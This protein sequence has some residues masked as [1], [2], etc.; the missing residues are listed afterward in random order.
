MGGDAYAAV[1]RVATALGLDTDAVVD[2]LA[3]KV[4]G[5]DL[6]SFLL[7]V[8][9]RR[10]EQLSPADIMRRARTDPLVEP[11]VVDAR[12]LHRVIG[13]VIDTIPRGFDVVELAPVVPLGTHSSVATVHQH[14][15]VSTIRNTE[16]AADPTN[17][18]AVL[19]ALRGPKREP[20]RL[21]AVQRILRAQPFG[22][23][24]QQH[25]SVLGLVTAGRDRGDLAFETDALVE[26]LHVLR[27]A[28]G[29][30]TNA[31][32]QIRLTDLAD[33]RAAALVQGAAES[34]ADDADTLVT[35]DPDRPT[36]R[37]YYRDLCFKIVA[38][39]TDREVEIGDGGFTDWTAQLL[40]DRKARLLT[41]GLGLDRLTSLTN[42]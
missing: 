21:A 3:T 27:S 6:T 40:N 14:K 24:G 42:C 29:T 34:F 36:G 1:R 32:V 9:R 41:S 39:T 23:Q 38:T 30:V 20:I 18:L 2:V 17:A 7:E 10:A 16:V 4:S 35:S 12:V 19:A 33:G 8:T 25:F 37:G 26:Q 22:D 11:G 15:V 5:A 13:A 28:I 31:T